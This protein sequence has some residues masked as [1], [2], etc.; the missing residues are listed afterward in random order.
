MEVLVE[1]LLAEFEI[2]PVYEED[3]LTDESQVFEILDD[4]YV[5]SNCGCPLTEI[6]MYNR[7]YCEYCDLHY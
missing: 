3:E 7:F 6:P 1:F 5:C 4:L 2:E